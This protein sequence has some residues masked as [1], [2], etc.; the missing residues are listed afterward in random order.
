MIDKDLAKHA[1]EF[2]RYVANNKFEETAEG[3][4]FPHAKATIAGVFNH[5]VNGQDEREDHNLV[6]AEGILNILDTVYH[7]ATQVPT[8]Y[9]SIFSGNVSPSSSWTAANYASNATE[10]TTDY[11]EASRPAFNEAAASAGATTNSANKAAFTVGAAT[12]T[13]WGA[14]LLSVATK[15]GTTGILN[16]AAKFSTS[17]TLYIT[18][19]FNLG[20]TLTLTSA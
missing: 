7:G 8:W 10:I 2:R 9:L 17:R 11:N 15:G 4:L 12:I 19:V 20:Y 13:I 1:G 14:A 16:S 3:L 18:D 5:N 6:T